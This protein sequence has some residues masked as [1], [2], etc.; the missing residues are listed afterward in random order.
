MSYTPSFR[1][2]GF[3]AALL[4]TTALAA[5]AG[6]FLATNSGLVAN[7]APLSVAPSNPQP[8]FAPLVA[9]VKPAVVQIAVIFPNMP[10][11]A[12]VAGTM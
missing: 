12:I 2:R 5:G 6:A 10:I 1:L 4:V 8:G 9:K 11:T 7:A 3:A